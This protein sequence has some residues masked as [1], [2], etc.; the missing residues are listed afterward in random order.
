MIW[1]K[2]VVTSGPTREWIDPVRYISNGS[3][4]ILG[5]HIA[6]ELKSKF[7]ESVTYIHGPILPEF[8]KP[9]HCNSL[10]VETTEDMLQKVLEETETADLLI[11][12]AA[13]VDFKPETS[14]EKKMKK[15][16]NPNPVLHLV[17]N[18]DILKALDRHLQSKSK[19]MLISNSNANANSSL[20]RIGFAAETNDLKDYALRKLQEKNLDAIVGNIVH[21]S[22]KGFGD[23]D[24]T[25][26]V[27][28]KLQTETILGPNDKQTLAEKLVALLSQKFGK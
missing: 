19:S 23:V 28:D 24:S 5:F 21:K 1:K 2:A 25:L 26:Y 9:K 15:E 4:G 11:M 18:P 8:Q 7:A 22:G 12:C 3:S 20:I 6:N 16:A 13:P 17:P 27:Y 14:S 10:S